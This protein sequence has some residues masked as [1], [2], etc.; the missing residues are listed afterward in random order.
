MPFS[1]LSII[2]V[3]IFV[4]VDVHD[5]DA[6]VD[7]KTDADDI[8]GRIEPGRLWSF[9]LC[10]LCHIRALQ[11][12]FISSFRIGW[13]LTVLTVEM[14]EDFRTDKFSGICG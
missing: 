2:L 3:G 1:L 5:N 11:V 12:T 7:V 6:D 4:D 10:A 8:P 14:W 9:L 13:F